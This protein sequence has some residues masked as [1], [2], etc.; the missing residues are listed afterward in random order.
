MILICNRLVM[1]IW[2]M[3]IVCWKLN[4]LFSSH[5]C[6]LLIHKLKLLFSKGIFSP[7]KKLFCLLMKLLNNSNSNL[8]A[9]RK[10]A[11][12]CMATSILLLIQIQIVQLNLFSWQTKITITFLLTNYRLSKI[13]W[14]KRRSKI[15]R[16]K[17][18]RDW[19][20]VDKEVVGL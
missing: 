20:L 19:L 10:V 1:P 18:W 17:F 8:L 7:N 16:I 11:H 6:V 13:S 14:S 3:E 12:S 5:K 15:F 2:S 9:S 4:R